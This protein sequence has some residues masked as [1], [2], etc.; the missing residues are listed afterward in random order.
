MILCSFVKYFFEKF[1]ENLFR[2]M[3]LRK[4]FYKP[5]RH[6]GTKGFKGWFIRLKNMFQSASLLLSACHAQAG[7]MSQNFGESPEKIKHLPKLENDDNNTLDNYKILEMLEDQ[8]LGQ[9]LLEEGVLTSDDLQKALAYKKENYSRSLVQALLDME[10]INEA[11]ILRPLARYYRTQYLTTEKL[12]ELE[13]PDAILKLVPVAT[14]E[15]YHLFP[16]QYKKS[17]KSLTVVMKN[18]TDVAAIDELKFVSGIGN[19]KALVSM[20]DA[21]QAAINKWYRGERTAFG[22]SLETAPDETDMSLYAPGQ[23]RDLPLEQDEDELLDIHSLVTGTQEKQRAGDS[24]PKRS[25]AAAEKSIFLGGLEEESAAEA[26]S[27]VAEE[28]IVIE[29]I[30]EDR[31]GIEEIVLKPV[32]PEELAPAPVKQEADQAPAPPKRTVDQKKYRM[33]MLVVEPHDQVRKFIVK[34]FSSEGYRVKGFATRKEAFA[35]MEKGEYDS[36]V[37]KERE[38][39]ESSLEFEDRFREQFPGVE[40]CITKDY[41]SAVI[42]ETQMMRRLTSSFLETLDVLVGLLEMESQGIQGHSHN[43][44][45]YAKLIASKLDLSPREV[46]AITLAVTLHDLGKKGLKHFTILQVDATTD[47]EEVME[48]AEIPVK[49]LGAAKFPFEI[50]P[51]IRH[52]FERWDGR[53]IPDGLKAENIPVGARIIA[54]VDAFEDLTNRYSGRETVEP[55]EALE[56]LNRQAGKLFDPRLLEIFMSVVRDD[57]YLRQMEVAQDRILIADTEM[58]LTTLLELRLI[59]SGYGVTIARDGEDALAKALAEKPSLIVTEVE[60]PR[61]DGFSFISELTADE[62]TKEIPFVFLSRK[63]DPKS[64]T[65]GLDLGAEDYITKPVKVDVLCA[66]LITMINRLK[67]EKKVEAPAEAGVTG[68]LSEMSLPDIIQILG[69]GRKTGVVTLTNNGEKAEIYLEEGRIINAR[70]DDLKGEEAFYRILYWNEGTFRIDPNPE[71]TERLINI[72]ND[73][74]MLEGFRRMDEAAHEKGEGT[75]DISIDGSDFF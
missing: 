4:D 44:A 46:D 11:D 28:E 61:K 39:G 37:I 53:G 14:S 25:G 67:A 42:G 33:R 29:D 55:S 56:L 40:L 35:E 22:V 19:I 3:Q 34:L 63:D 49:L 21:I 9:L 59:K 75:E 50:R 26:K 62:S 2:V 12:S 16:V 51:I 8:K 47:A 71:T 30:K 72:S 41:G 32:K 1:S 65:R 24:E 18:P 58:D 60:L 7:R 69:A 68:S 70:I 57:I 15:R 45:K 27:G 20:E 13:V 36:L 48:Q 64:V 31:P 10:L 73:S 52:Q 6:Q 17:E 66:K 74:L 5:P 38:L 23:D 54:I 43:V